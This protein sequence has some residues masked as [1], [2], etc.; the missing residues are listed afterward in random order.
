MLISS[1][2]CPL[3]CPYF[4]RI[5][6]VLSLSFCFSSVSSQYSMPSMSLSLSF[7]YPCSVCVFV[8]SLTSCP[9]PGQLHV[10]VQLD[11]YFGCVRRPYPF[12]CLGQCIPM[13]CNLSCPLSVPPHAVVFINRTDHSFL[14]ICSNFFLSLLLRRGFF[15]SFPIIFVIP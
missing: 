9:C 2:L 3:T 10:L 8:W 13:L 6:Y 14:L 12:P 1:C 7:P 4:C 15:V 5:L 11:S